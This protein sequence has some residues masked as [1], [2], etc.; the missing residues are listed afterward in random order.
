M[1]VDVSN[2]VL[3]L[4][5][6]QNDFCHPD[7]VFARNGFG[8]MVASADEI[9]PRIYEVTKAAKEAGI[10]VVTTKLT[11][12][13][14]RDGRGIGLGQ[15]RQNL[16]D[17]MVHEGFREGTWGQ[18]VLDRFLEPEVKP[19][20]DV[21][22]WGHSAMYLTELEKVLQALGARTLIFVGLGTNGVVE[23][24][25]RDA[26]SRALKVVTVEDCVTAPIRELHEGGLKSLAHI[27]DVVSSD[28]VLDALRA[29]RPAVVT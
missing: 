25:A 7:G 22:K 12:L 9:A 20:Y 27:G 6:M 15:F 24:T 4:M 26:V 10:P 2:T 8:H 23:G 1:Q 18:Q 11:V 17:F 19:D 21:R 5:D 28:E 3:M 14:D 16:Q 29:A 13:T